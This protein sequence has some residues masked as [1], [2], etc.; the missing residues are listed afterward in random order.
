MYCGGQGI[1]SYYLTKALA[2][3]GHEVH[4]VAGPPYPD[5]PESVNLHKIP[6]PNFYEKRS[7]AFKEM[8]LKE[9]FHPLNLYEWVATK[10][11]NFPEILGFSLRAIKKIKKLNEKIEFDVIHDNQCIGYGFLITNQL[12]VPQV[13]TIHHPLKI[14]REKSI[15]ESE[16]FWGK[17]GNILYYPLI[18]QRLSIKGFD[19]II[20]VSE[21]SVDDIKKYFGI[22]KEKIQVIHNGIDEE[23]FKP[24]NH[25]KD[26]KI[27][28]EKPEMNHYSN[29]SKFL[30]VGETENKHKGFRILL[31][32]LDRL[33]DDGVNCELRVIN[34]NSPES[35][36]TEKLIRKY[37]LED[38]VEYIGKV[39]TLELVE[40][41]SSAT[42]VVMPSLHE[43]FGLPAIE[44][45]SC[46]TPL[47]ATTSGALSEI[48]PSEAGIL[49][50]PKD[51]NKLADALKTIHQNHELQEKMGKKGREKVKTQFTWKRAAKKVTKV[52]KEAKHAAND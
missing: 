31:R 10:F 9:I 15:N 35:E 23:L 26:S 32:A 2:K 5:K 51:E 48:V 29:G 30:F 11:G 24:S 12:K 1:Y 43:G 4:L 52:Y 50:P 36:Y 42:A 16:T 33:N 41:Y 14:D 28:A 18:M 25:R 47:I 7:D 21:A 46:E 3:L 34:G 38:K 37:G 8:G 27:S 22:Q 19:K 39:S 6:N 44:A 40:E 45:M 49:V 20:T 17:L 13:A